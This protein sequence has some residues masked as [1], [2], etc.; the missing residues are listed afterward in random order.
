MSGIGVEREHMKRRR[1]PVDAN[2]YTMPIFWPSCLISESAE[3]LTTEPISGLNRT[4]ERQAGHQVQ[5]VP[6]ETQRDLDTFRPS[7]TSGAPTR[8]PGRRQNAGQGPL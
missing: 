6:D 3:L 5:T 1:R 2:V 7:T 8:L 4:E